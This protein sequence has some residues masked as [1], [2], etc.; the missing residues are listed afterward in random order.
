MEHVFNVMRDMF[1]TINYYLFC[2]SYRI[3]LCVT[4][5]RDAPN[6]GCSTCLDS[7][8]K[9]CSAPNTM[10]ACT[11]CMDGYAILGLNCNSCSNPF[12]Q[13]CGFIASGSTCLT[14]IDQYFSNSGVCQKCSSKFA[15]CLTCDLTVCFDCQPG[16]VLS[17][18]YCIPCRNFIP[19]CTLCSSTTVCTACEIDGYYYDSGAVGCAVCSSSPSLTNC[20]IC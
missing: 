3:F 9:I 4:F 1:A 17:G 10:N 13:L 11:T 12:C 15:N 7:N 16:S 5:S 18:I 20:A 19:G 8:C 6:S 2:L 14:C